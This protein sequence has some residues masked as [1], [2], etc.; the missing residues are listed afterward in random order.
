MSTSRRIGYLD[1]AKGVCVLLVIVGHCLRSL[2]SVILLPYNGGDLLSVRVIYSFHMP[3]F[4]LISG[5]LCNTAKPLSTYVFEKTRRLIW[6]MFLWST[7][8]FCIKLLIGGG[9]RNK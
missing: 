8:T 4:M 6:P 7:I 9:W 3:L 5:F 1:F 2:A